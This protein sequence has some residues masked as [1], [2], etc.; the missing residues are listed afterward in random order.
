MA[1]TVAISYGIW[2]VDSGT[3]SYLALRHEVVLFTFILLNRPP[4]P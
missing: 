3:Y 4:V 2:W 1:K